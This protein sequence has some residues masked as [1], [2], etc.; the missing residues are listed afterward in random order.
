MAEGAS[1]DLALSEGFQLVNLR[2]G[3]DW[4]KS[5]ALRGYQAPFQNNA[6]RV[7]AFFRSALLVDLVDLRR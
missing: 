6:Y 3:G 2:S 5:E 1:L 7:G 4:S